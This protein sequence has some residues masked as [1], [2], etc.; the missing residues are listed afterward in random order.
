MEERVA[1]K[2]V[3]LGWKCRAFDVC[4]RLQAILPLGKRCRWSVGASYWPAG[5]TGWEIS[6]RV[7]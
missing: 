5:L 2:Y 4:W 6:F 1:G 3:P 7:F